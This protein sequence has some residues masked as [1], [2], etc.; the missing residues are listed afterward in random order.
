MNVCLAVQVLSAKTAAAVNILIGDAASETV[1][2]VNLIN[3]WFDCLN[4]NRLGLDNPN[5]APNTSVN[6]THLQVI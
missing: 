1:A 5:L 2:F 6:D 3:D 4:F